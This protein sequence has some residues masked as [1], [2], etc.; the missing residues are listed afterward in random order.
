MGKGLRKKA[1]LIQAR[2]SSKRFPGKVLKK[3]AGMPLIEY[4]Y[5]RCLHARLADEVIILTSVDKRD[6]RL[7]KFC[8]VKNIPVFRGD[9]NNVLRRYIRAASENNVGIICRVCADSPFV[10]IRLID[11]MF[12]AVEREGLDYFSVNKEKCIS[13]LDSEVVTLEA[14][15]KIQGNKPS[16]EELEHVTLYIKNR[17]NQFKVRFRDERLKPGFLAQESLTVDYPKDLVFCN[18]I[19]RR[20]NGRRNFTSSDIFDILKRNKSLSH[21][22]KKER[23]PCS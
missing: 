2:L 16:R 9:L 10:D 6:D 11:K 19:A 14:L 4:I 5:K 8:R 20:L 15:R 21:Q 3:I 17:R 18:K 12:K 1:I 23:L 7:S 13:G 22:H